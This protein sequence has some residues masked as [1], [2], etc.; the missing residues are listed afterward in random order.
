MQ[1]RILIC[2]FF[3]ALL[4]SLCG[5]ISIST[6]TEKTQDIT[7]ADVPQPART[8]IEMLTAGG[9][10]RKLEK[11][12]IGRKV[13]YDVEATVQGKDVEY[14]IASNGIVLTAQQSIEY[15]ALPAAVQNAVQKYFGPATGLKAYREVEDG[16]VFYE[17]EGT[18]D[19]KP[20]AL[21]LSC[22]GKIV[23]EER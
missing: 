8:M 20:V 2:V 9:Q 18:K 4:F 13:I 22:N 23:E 6:K 17:I 5:C 11:E 1:N 15:N 10:I 3:A 19:N 21:K 14:D 16:S 12:Q 7:I